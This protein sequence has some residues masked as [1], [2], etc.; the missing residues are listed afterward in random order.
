M[1]V[2]DEKSLTS[3][4]F[5]NIRARLFGENVALPK[6]REKNILRKLFN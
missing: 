1:N 2:L 3:E 4:C 6:Y 5:E